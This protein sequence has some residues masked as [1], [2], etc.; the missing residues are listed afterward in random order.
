MLVYQAS[1]VVHVN[2]SSFTGRSLGNMNET[3]SFLPGPQFPSSWSPD[4]FFLVSVGTALHSF[5][6]AT[7]PEAILHSVQLRSISES[8]GVH[9][10]RSLWSRPHISHLAP[11]SSRPASYPLSTSCAPKIHGSYVSQI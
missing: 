11:A 10:P 6:Q 9:F 2:F 1:R 7:H 8:C 5:V 4:P 3:H